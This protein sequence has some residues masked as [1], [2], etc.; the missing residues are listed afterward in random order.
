M[1]KYLVRPITF[2][3]MLTCML[4]M[5]VVSHAEIKAG[6]TNLTI[7]AGGYTQDHE[8][9]L[10]KDVNGDPVR[11]DLDTSYS[12]GVGLGYN[13]T[14]HFGAEV[15]YNHAWARLDKEGGISRTVKTD[16]YHLDL[17]YH[18][19]P[20]SKCVFYGLIGGGGIVYN[21]VD[22]AVDDQQD[23]MWNY[24]LG[25]KYFMTRA[26]AFRG[27]VRGIS[28]P[29][30]GVGEWNNN[31]LYNIGLVFAFGNA[32]EPKPMP[33]PEPAPVV[34]PAPAPAPEPAPAPA[35]API[36]EKG[37]QT[38]NVEFDTNKAVVKE[39]YYDELNKFA[40]VMKQNPDLKVEIDGH[41]DSVGDAKSN[42]KLSQKRAESIRNYLVTKGGIDASRVSAKGYGESKPIADN[43]NKEGRQKNR[44]VEA[45]VEYEKT[46]QPQ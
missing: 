23:V 1:N 20:D 22:N 32:E 35:P 39:K 41:T 13:F 43:M 37:R 21:G 26:L 19:N 11:I 6:S 25:F 8:L 42:Q 33:A 30:H 29:L 46:V 18:F 24:G 17:L 38:L 31:V 4:F 27:D 40:D 15:G 34:E 12:A 28:T 2:L 44:R 36:I 5:P 7:F 3:F 16:L 14:K 10:V 9:L 45:V